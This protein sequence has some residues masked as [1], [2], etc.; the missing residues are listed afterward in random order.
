MRTR[1]FCAGRSPTPS[2]PSRGS[3]RIAAR[4]LMRSKTLQVV[5]AIGGALIVA[6][7]S[8]SLVTAWLPWAQF[9][10]L[11]GIPVALPAVV[12]SCGVLAAAAALAALLLRRFP[13]FCL[14]ACAVLFAA[15]QG[16]ETQI[17]RAVKK[18]LI[19]VQISLFPINRL[20]DQFH[21]PN[22]EAGNYGE[23]DESFLG[24]GVRYALDSAGI[25]LLGC[26]LA[27]PRDP[28][29]AAAYGRL[30]RS[31]CASCGAAWPSSRNARHCPSCGA[32]TDPLTCSQCG[33]VGLESDKYCIACGAP[34][35]SARE[36]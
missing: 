29:I 10:L 15:A 14:L 27:L 32:P 21:I 5:S 4:M 3:F 8:L 12:F 34:V 28:I 25:L 19:G 7:G 33:T 18:R 1:A 13:L 36:I 6:G 24:S 11:G 23:P 20:L 17:P 26:L 9:K 35:K 31:R 30:A 22:I 16:A 2:K